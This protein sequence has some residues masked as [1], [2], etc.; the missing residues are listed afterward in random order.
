MQQFRTLD[1]AIVFVRNARGIALPTHLRD[2]FARATSSVALNLA[3]GS[4][5]SS[6][7]DRARFYEIALGSLRE[8]QVILRIVLDDDAPLARQADVLAAHV[9]KLVRG[10]RATC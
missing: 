9:F 1:L 4:A 6:P 3:E 2:Q 5:K 10:T 8:S 7:R